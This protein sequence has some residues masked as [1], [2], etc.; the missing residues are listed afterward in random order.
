[1]EGS[2]TQSATE[3]VWYKRPKVWLIICVVIVIVILLCIGGYFL[4]KKFYGEKV[5]PKDPV[6]VGTYEYM[7][8][9]YPPSKVNE[10]VG[11]HSQI[12]ID[13][14]QTYGSPKILTKDKVGASYRT[15]IGKRV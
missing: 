13:A 14:K 5:I 4:Y 6:K 2:E 11:S 3:V 8:E 1:M 7:E 9:T 15:V 10:D 12:S